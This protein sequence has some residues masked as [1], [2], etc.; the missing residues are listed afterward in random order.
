MVLERVASKECSTTRLIGR[1]LDYF[2][3]SKCFG[4]VRA[5]HLKETAMS[6]HKFAQTE[7]ASFVRLHALVRKG[8]RADL[9]VQS[10]TGFIRLEHPRGAAAGAPSLVL[11]SDGLIHGIDNVQA[12]NSREGDPDCIYAS[13]EADWEL[14][15]SFVKG[16]PEPTSLQALN[17]T[18]FWEVKTW[19]TIYLI[20]GALTVGLAFLGMLGYRLVVGQLP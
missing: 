8:Y 13:D 2:T 19:I 20:L 11:H 15:Q 10:D 6:N 17:S 5:C 14:F 4:R 3:A 1:G 9:G 16:V 12:L 18:M 7:A